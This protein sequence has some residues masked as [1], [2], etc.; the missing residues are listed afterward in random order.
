MNDK[1]IKIKIVKVTQEPHD[2]GATLLRIKGESGG[3]IYEF[4]AKED[5]YLDEHKRISIQELMLKRVRD[6]RKR[7][8]RTKEQKD[9]QQKKVVALVGTEIVEDE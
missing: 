8:V 6:D 3:K 5:E 9:D 7:T 1:K 4:A 2:G